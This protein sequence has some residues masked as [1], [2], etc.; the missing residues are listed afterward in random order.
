MASYNLN[1]VRVVERPEQYFPHKEIVSRNHDGSLIR[2]TYAHF[3]RRVR[4]LASALTSIGVGRGIGR[5][6]GGCGHRIL[7]YCWW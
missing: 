4:R 2:Y 5:G 6:G 3:S 7:P 1:L